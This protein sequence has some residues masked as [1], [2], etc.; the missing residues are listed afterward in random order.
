MIAGSTGG[1]GNYPNVAGTWSIVAFPLRNTCAIPNPFPVARDTLILSQNGALLS[2]TASRGALFFTGEVEPNGD[3][4]LI[5]SPEPGGS[6]AC[7][8]SITPLLSGNFLTE[9][10]E[11]TFDV[12]FSLGC[13]FSDCEIVFAGTIRRVTSSASAQSAQIP[14]GAEDLIMFLEETGAVLQE[15]IESEK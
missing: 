15:L 6:G 12:D 1:G 3:F 13:S 4:E 14:E 2:G 11:V 5:G 7:T 10:V 9:R 8:F